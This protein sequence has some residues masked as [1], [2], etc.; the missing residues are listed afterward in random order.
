[1]FTRKPKEKGKDVTRANYDQQPTCYACPAT[2]TVNC[3]G[4]GVSS[5][6]Q[7]LRTTYMLRAGGYPF[8]VPLTESFC[9]RCYF[10]AKARQWLVGIFAAA[11][12]L[13]ILACLVWAVIARY[14]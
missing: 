13:A 10:S 2:A 7:H 5:C 12:F 3:D 1:V 8:S 6:P 4:C 11:V 14:F 9:R